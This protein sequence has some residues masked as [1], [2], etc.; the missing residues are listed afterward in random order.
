M[1]LKFRK[2]ICIYVGKRYMSKIR[3]TEMCLTLERDMSNLERYISRIRKRNILRNE[4]NSLEI[5]KTRT[6]ILNRHCLKCNF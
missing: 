6:E 1:C 2:E 5:R 3:K 4:V